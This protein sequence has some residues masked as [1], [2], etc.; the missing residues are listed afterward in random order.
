[1]VSDSALVGAGVF[2]FGARFVSGI[3]IGA[4]PVEDMFYGGALYTLAVTAYGWTG[5]ALARLRFL[6]R[7]SRPFSWINTALPGL[8][9]GIAI[10]RPG[11]A[12]V[13]GTL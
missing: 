2:A 5:G 11:L 4:M 7:S 6:L 12:L 10:G 9:C 1:M 8:A 13:A 3:R